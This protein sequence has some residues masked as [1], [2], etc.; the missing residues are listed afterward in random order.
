MSRI[1]FILLIIKMISTL[2][3]SVHKIK[4]AFAFYCQLKIGNKI[5]IENCH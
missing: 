3:N 5:L 2:A 4:L 1:M